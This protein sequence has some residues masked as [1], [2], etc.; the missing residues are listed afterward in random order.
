MADVEGLRFDDVTTFLTV[1]Q[2]RSIS[3]AARQLGVTPSQV[4]KAVARLER[5]FGAPLLCRTARGV[6]ASMAGLRAIPMLETLAR[7][8]AQLRTS[9]STR[10]HLRIAAPSALAASLADWLVRHRP[11][12]RLA[13]QELTC[14]AISSALREDAFDVALSLEA[15]PLGDS[16]LQE[17]VGTLECALFGNPSLAARLGKAPLDAQ[18]LRDVP[19]VMP[20]ELVAGAA[21]LPRDL[22]PR[23]PAQRTPGDFAAC[24]HVALAIARRSDQLLFAPRAATE[25][26]VTRG[27]L[28]EIPVRDWSV[29]APLYLAFHETRV[30]APT[31]NALR[32]SITAWLGQAAVRRR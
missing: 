6:S 2:A 32:A 15:L 10:P 13:F 20:Y 18:A 23:A 1:H 30:L 21:A 17:H 28:V 11:H 24:A 31:A 29:H 4:S 12:P 9:P 14:P 3:S 7:G 19:F 22:C 8:L 27:E 26:S 16:F 25:D 5:F